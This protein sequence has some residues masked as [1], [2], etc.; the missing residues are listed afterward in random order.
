MQGSRAGPRQ[1]LT[2]DRAQARRS[3]P[4]ACRPA[5][6]DATC[7]ESRRYRP[8]AGRRR[9]P[10]RAGRLRGR[11][12]SRLRRGHVASSLTRPSGLL[13]HAPQ[14]T[15]DSTERRCL[16]RKVFLAAAVVAAVAL[17]AAPAHAQIVTLTPFC[18]STT[19]GGPGSGFRIPGVSPTE[20]LAEVHLSQ[21]RHL[22]GH[23]ERQ[24]RG[25][26][27]PAGD[28]P[29]N[30]R[31]VRGPQRQSLGRPRRSAAR[32]PAPRG[33]LRANPSTSKD[34]CKNGGW[35]NF[36]GFKNQ[37]GCVSFVATGGGTPASG[38]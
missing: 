2:R 4:Q 1:S 7:T 24:P 34:Q 30:P 12:L 10:A 11:R 21:P 36:P 14:G 9:L 25:G 28:R 33:P 18:D 26:Q 3:H 38:S 13:G 32:N 29:Y 16:M 31:G 27:L 19:T 35:R 5:L 20:P 8:R 17:S 15:L 6:A 22:H 37:G 23:A